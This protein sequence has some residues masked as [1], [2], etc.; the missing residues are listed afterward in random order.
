MSHFYT[1][2]AMKQT[3]LK[4]AAKIVLYWLADHYN[5]KTGLCF[6]SLKTLAEECEMN[7]STVLRHLDALEEMGFIVRDRRHRENGSLTSNLYRLTLKPVAEYDYPS[8][9]MRPAPVADYDHHTNLGN[10]NLGNEQGYA[11]RVAAGECVQQELLPALNVQIATVQSKSPY[12][13]GLADGCRSIDEEFEG[14]WKY[15]PRKVGKKEARNAWAK[16]RKAQTFQTISKPL[17][18]FIR[19]Q[20]STP[21]DKI[22]HLA[23]WLNKERWDGDQTHARNRAET[24]SDRL[25]R[26]GAAPAGASGDEIAG[27]TRT[28]PEIELRID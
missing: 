14:V 17:G 8:G 15:Y 23:T 16:A 11:H 5:E 24:T 19:I 26:L 20:R 25:D 21:M 10:T 9:K 12:R 18:E 6:P 28:P 27:P 2:W 7:R 3:G 13:G 22:P 4:P 1:G